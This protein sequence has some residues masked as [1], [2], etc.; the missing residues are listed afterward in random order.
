M[1][2]ITTVSPPSSPAPQTTGTPH[3]AH[4]A[5]RLNLRGSIDLF[6]DAMP[7]A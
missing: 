1:R 4:A 6:L 7:K 5:L 2:R 3:A